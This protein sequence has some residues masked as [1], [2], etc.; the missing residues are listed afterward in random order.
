[1]TIQEAIKSGKPFRL[2]NWFHNGRKIFYAIVGRTENNNL[3][4]IVE[5]T[6]KYQ[7]ILCNGVAP[8]TPPRRE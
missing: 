3:E 1:M 4:I 2:P 6:E 5:E 8:N 7:I